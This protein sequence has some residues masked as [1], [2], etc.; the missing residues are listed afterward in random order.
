M[1]STQTS[2]LALLNSAEFFKNSPLQQIFVEAANS[3]LQ[4]PKLQYLVTPL[5]E[6][7]YIVNGNITMKGRLVLITDPRKVSDLQLSIQTKNHLIESLNRN[8]LAT[9]TVGE[10]SIKGC[11]SFLTDEQFNQVSEKVLDEMFDRQQK[12]FTPSEDVSAY[13]NTINDL[14]LKQD[15]TKEELVVSF[16]DEVTDL[17]KGEVVNVESIKSNKPKKT[18]VTKKEKV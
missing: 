4:N 12:G 14:L 6:N 1:N 2:L 17:E 8:V 9:K 11:F 7:G 16:V 3:I 18:K 15:E 10:H 13:I 5:V